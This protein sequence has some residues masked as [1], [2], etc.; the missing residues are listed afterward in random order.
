MGKLDGKVAIVT[1]AA[2][3]IG[4]AYA[5]ALAEEG[6]KVA[7]VDILD[8]TKTMERIASEVAG[9]ELAA[10]ECDIS[11]EKATLALVDDV[12]GKFGSLHVLINNAALFGTL[13]PQPFDEI[14]IDLW[15]KVQSVNVRGMLLMCRAAMKAFQPQKYGKIVN[16]GS[17]TILKGV[18]FM[19]HYVTSKGGVYAMTRCLAKELGAYNISINTLAPG[20]TMSEAVLGWGPEGDHDKNLVIQSRALK[21]EQLP[22]DLIGACVFLSSPESDFMTG[23]YVAVNG[24]DCFS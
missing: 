16:V 9:A 2:Q 21:R 15:D 14:D 18:P 7:I 20:L 4:A 3:G 8:G 6:A 23:Q 24:G 11:D 10:F 17:D 1:G 13:K 12:L 19:L 22:D 5:K